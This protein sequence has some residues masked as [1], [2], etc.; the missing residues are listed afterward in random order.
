MGCLLLCH[1]LLRAA[2]DGARQRPVR[3]DT[4]SKLLAG[5]CSWHDG[6]SLDVRPHCRQ[7]RLESLAFG[8]QHAHELTPPGQQ[9]RDLL[10]RRVLSP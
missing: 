10:G 2:H 3:R 1:T 6:M 4:P 7:R 8:G 9:R 5:S